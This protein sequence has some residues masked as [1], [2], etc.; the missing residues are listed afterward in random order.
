QQQYTQQQQQQQQSTYYVQPAGSTQAQVNL[1]ARPPPPP[2]AQQNQRV[3][4]VIYKQ[5]KVRELVRS[6]TLVFKFI[7]VFNTLLPTATSNI[8]KLGQKCSNS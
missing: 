2:H 3:D 5:P 6:D 7:E 1:Q 4:G 8:H